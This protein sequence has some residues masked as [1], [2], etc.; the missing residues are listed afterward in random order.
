MDEEALAAEDG[1]RAGPGS[2]AA[3]TV[4]GLLGGALGE[5]DAAVFAGEDGG[6]GGV[7]G[8]LWNR[9]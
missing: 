1:M 6:E 4:I 2:E 9:T 8:I 5:V 7:A 3:P